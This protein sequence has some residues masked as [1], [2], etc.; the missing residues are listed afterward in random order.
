MADSNEKLYK[1]IAAAVKSYMDM[2]KIATVSTDL[3]DAFT[4]VYSHGKAKLYLRNLFTSLMYAGL[5]LLIWA[6]NI[7]YGFVFKLMLTV[8][9]FLIWDN[10][11]ETNEAVQSKRLLKAL[12]KLFIENT[13]EWTPD[14]KGEPEDGRDQNAGQTD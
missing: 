10:T 7:E 6:S 5:L 11:I 9:L 8:G 12:D 13:D 1:E 14:T 2:H 4:A 3:V